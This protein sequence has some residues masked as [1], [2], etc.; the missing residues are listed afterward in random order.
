LENA[1]GCNLILVD[2]NESMQAIGG[3]A[4][5]KLIEVLD[6]HKMD[7]RYI[8]PIEINVRPWG[9][10]N[11]IIASLFYQHNMEIEKNLAGLMLSA[12]L[13]D[14]VIT[15]SPTC[16]ENDKKFIIEL[17]Q[18]ANISNWQEYGLEIFRAKSC[19]KE[20]K[21]EQIVNNDFKDFITKSGKFGI[22]QV[23][24]VDLKEFAGKENELLAALDKLRGVGEY[25]SVILFITDIMQEGSKFLISS[26][27][28]NSVA[29]AL[30]TKLK[31]HQVYI[32]G[33]M[34]RKKQVAPLIMENFDK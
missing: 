10:S 13:D 34:S 33:I 26:N 28:E 25:H 30:G 32:P 12:I 9:S 24:T 6:H 20:M 18:L 3:L 22:G 5:A 1:A 23:E 8:E 19:I 21:A 31:D 17:A 4:N 15:K 27:D 2:H 16:T 29:M 11:S 14:T 7:F